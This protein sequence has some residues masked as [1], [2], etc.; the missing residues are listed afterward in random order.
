MTLR[1][2]C[3]VT[4]PWVLLDFVCYK[5]NCDVFHCNCRQVCQLSEYSYSICESFDVLSS[6]NV[7]LKIYLLY[8]ILVDYF[9][10]TNI[11]TFYFPS[12]LYHPIYVIYMCMYEECCYLER[13]LSRDFHGFTCFPPL[14]DY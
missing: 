6:K 5:I 3:T 12:Y 2:K 1:V 14:P 8:I 9:L 13:N 7:S 4:L 11:I 10:F